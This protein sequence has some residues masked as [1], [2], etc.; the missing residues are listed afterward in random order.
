MI[1]V[2][3]DPIL[4]AQQMNDE[5]LLRATTKH[6][7]LVFD[8]LEFFVNQMFDH[9]EKHDYTKLEKFPDYHLAIQSGMIKE[10]PWYKYH[11]TEE[12]HHLLANVADDVN[13][14]DVMEYIC[15]CVMAGSA[16]SDKI[17]DITLSDEVLQKAF[18][19]TVDMLKKEVV[20]KEGVTCQPKRRRKKNTVILSE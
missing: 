3:K 5:Q 2:I 6:M 19:N 7:D 12:R 13:L 1:K 4:N 15:D 11:I 17:Y 20:V 10:S 18:K 8:G 14:I 16:R 9:G